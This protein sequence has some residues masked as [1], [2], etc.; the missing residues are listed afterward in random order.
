MGKQQILNFMRQFP[1]AFL[2]YTEIAKGAD[3][4]QYR[5][6]R[7]WARPF[8]RGLVEEDLVER[9]AQGGYRIVDEERDKKKHKKE[10]EPRKVPGE[11]A[12]ATTEAAQPK[13]LAAYR[14]ECLRRMGGW[15]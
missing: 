5:R 13:D 10:P 3:R 15:K 11:S 1:D 14:E 7:D 9:D 6:D 2:S 12:S 4:K 8:L